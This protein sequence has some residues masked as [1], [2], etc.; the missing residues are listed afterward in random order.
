[1][2]IQCNTGETNNG[3]RS[4]LML[5]LHLKFTR[6]IWSMKFIWIYL[7]IYLLPQN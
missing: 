2:N 1:M 5:Y 7:Q 4:V 6:A 3:F